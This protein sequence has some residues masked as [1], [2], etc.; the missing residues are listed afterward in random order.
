MKEQSAKAE[1]LRFPADSGKALQMKENLRCRKRTGRG[2]AGSG[3]VISQNAGSSHQ[4]VEAAVPAQKRKPE[5][6]DTYE[7]GI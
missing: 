6:E 2:Y 3:Q 5:D 1:R 7:G 4:R